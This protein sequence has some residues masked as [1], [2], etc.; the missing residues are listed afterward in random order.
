[1][2]GQPPPRPPTR[3]PARPQSR[4]RS[5][6]TRLFV[7]I[8]LPLIVVAGLSSVVLQWLSREMSHNLYDDTLR[9]VAHT[10]AREV[11]LTK[12]DLVTDSLLDSLVG[13][14]GDPIYYQVRADGGYF[15]AGHS[16]APLPDNPPDM[17][18]GVPVFFDA[19]Y[20]GEPVR[21]V[22]LREFISDPDFDGWT[23]VEVWQTVTQRQ[24]LS[25]RMLAQSA[26]VLV[27]LLGAAAVLIWFGIRRGLAPL[28]DLRAALALRGAHDLR[29]IRRPVPPEARPLVTTINTLFARLSAEL[30][31]RNAFISNAAHQLRNPVAAI[32]AQA[33]AARD[34]RTPGDQAERLRDLTDTARR[35]SR[36]SRQLLRLDAASQRRLPEDTPPADLAGLASEVA[37]RYVPAALRAD[38]EIEYDGPQTPLFVRGDPVLIEEL[39]DNLIDNALRYGCPPGSSLRLAVAE[40]GGRAVLTVADEG[41]GIPPDDTE[42]VFERFVRLSHVEDGGCGLGLPIVRAIARGAGGTARVVPTPR[43]CTIRVALPLHG[44]GCAPSGRSAEKA[45]K[46]RL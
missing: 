2:P 41:P 14:L 17:P 40:S 34:S 18:G 26:V 31:R 35:L 25:M 1:M 27:L 46:I 15:L 29:P 9:V 22:I 12:G 16:D 30:E 37:R 10:V 39:I 5:L 4:A 32:Q 24:A 20:H 28:T 7:T 45:Q 3:P 6:R 38:I 36:M 44:A 33:E 13:A 23:T 11:V 8:M 21:A 43:G 42:K 19:V